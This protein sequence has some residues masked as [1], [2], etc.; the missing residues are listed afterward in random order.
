MPETIGPHRPGDPR[1]WLVF[2][3]LPDDLQLAEDSTL[4][5]DYSSQ[6]WLRRVRNRPATAT[7]RLLLEH[8]GHAL[9]AELTTRVEYFS[10]TFRNRRWPALEE[11]GS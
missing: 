6:H 10:P 1:G 3:W 7:E 9:P 2:E 11:A 5:N 4:E 8:L